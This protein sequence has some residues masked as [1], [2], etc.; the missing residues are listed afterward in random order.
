MK[1]KNVIIIGAGIGG[2]TA[3]IHLAK[4]GLQVTV[5]DKNSHAGGRCDHIS[6]DGHHFDTGPTLMVMPLLYEAEF[7]ALGASMHDLLDLQRVRP[8]LPPRLRR[9]QPAGADLGF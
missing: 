8:D 3:A 4:H 1:T 6:R 2:L 5:L 7:A 9:W